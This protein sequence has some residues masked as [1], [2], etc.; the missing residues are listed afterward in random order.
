M[1]VNQMS[2]GRINK[3]KKKIIPDWNKTLINF[4]KLSSKETPSQF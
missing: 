1:N 3:V 4:N 2:E